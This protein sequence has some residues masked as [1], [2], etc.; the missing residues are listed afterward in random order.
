MIMEGIVGLVC[1]IL[2]AFPLF[3][4]GH[5][6]KNS[7]D[8]LTF[9]AGDKSL[10]EKVKDIQGYNNEISKLYKMCLGICGNRDTLFN[11]FLVRNY[12]CFI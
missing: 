9:W 6:N 1:C 7:R 11:I 4:M 5:Y 3:V 10:K 8:P 12:L 2:C